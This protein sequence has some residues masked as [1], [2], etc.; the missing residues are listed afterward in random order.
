M[1]TREMV[2]EFRTTQWAQMIQER[3]SRQQK[4]RDFCQEAGVSKNTYYYWQR[5]VR[6]ALCERMLEKPVGSPPA[7]TG[8]A[9]FAEVKLVETHESSTLPAP[10]AQP[11]SP[12]SPGMTELGKLCVE[13]G[14]LRITIDSGYPPEKLAALLRECMRS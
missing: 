9:R 12:A 14:E 7:G 1:D 3:V 2:S 10:P 5:K 11:A 8:R 4:I 6:Q 13:T